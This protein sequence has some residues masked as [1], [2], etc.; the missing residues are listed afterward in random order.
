MCC[1]VTHSGTTPIDVVKTQ[2]QLESAKYTSFISADK[3]IISAEGSGA[4]STGV[5][6]TSQGYFVQGWF[7]FGGVEICKTRFA[8]G[9]SEQDARKNR[10][11]NTLGGSA[12]AEFVADVFLCANEACR[13]RSVSDPSYANGM[14][15][16]GQKLVADNGV[17]NGLY[18]GFGPMLF[19]Q[20]SCTMAKINV[21]QKVAETICQ[22]LGTSPSEMSKGAVL[23]V[24]LGSDVAAGV[25]AP[26]ATIPHTTDGVLS[27]VNKKGAAGEGSMMVRLRRI[28]GACECLNFVTV[29]VAQQVCLS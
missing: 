22:N 19:K 14:L 21:Q 6:P 15:A 11:V 5:M 12:V 2:M 28:A 10:D 18:S 24:S 26:T 13:I 23:P 1:S 3:N 20:I 7:K 4:L 27:E 29:T 16:T 9:M 17:D 25:A 8:M